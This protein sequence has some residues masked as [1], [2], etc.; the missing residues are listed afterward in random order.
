MSREPSKQKKPWRHDARLLNKKDLKI[1]G[2]SILDGAL[3]FYDFVIYVSCIHL[4]FIPLFFSTSLS[5]FTRELLIWG[6]FAIGYLARP[7][8]N[9]LMFHFREKFGYKPMLVLNVAMIMLPTFILYFLPTYQAIGML[10]PIL[11]LLV[12]ILQGIAMGF[13]IPDF[14]IFTAEHAPKER[15]GFS[16]GILTSGILSGITL[17]FL[18][19]IITNEYFSDSDVISYAWRIPFIIGGVICVILTCM[20]LFFPQPLF[21]KELTARKTFEKNIPTLFII[22][23]HKAACILVVLMTWILSTTIIVGILMA[24]DRVLG[25]LCKIQKT[26]YLIAGCI[27]SF[28]L[29]IGCTLFGWLD[30]RIGTK[31]NMFIAWGGLAMTSLYFF[32]SLQDDINRSL[33]YFNYGLFGLF[34]GAVVT[35]PI[36]GARVFPSAIRHSGLMFSYSLTYTI[37]SGITPILCLILLKH[38]NLLDGYTYLGPAIY[39]SFAAIIAVLL[40]FWSLTQWGWQEQNNY[41]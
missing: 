29:A 27:A 25:D 19:S 20:R 14:W 22:K 12:R 11:L 26:N 35:M 38:D 10:A 31:K 3:E 41:K 37:S 39:I 32:A 6:I 16:L 33:I 34:T 9:I 30:D 40:S 24:P 28:M 7:I 15:Y 21:S 23:H 5:V 4:I 18:V 1:L 8:G 13:K 36:I 2:L 17:G